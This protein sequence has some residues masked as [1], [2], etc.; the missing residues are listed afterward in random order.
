MR[1]IIRSL[2]IINFCIYNSHSIIITY[3][4]VLISAYRSLFQ[5]NAI[6]SLSLAICSTVSYAAFVLKL[7]CRGLM[8][9]CVIR[10]HLFM[11]KKY[12]FTAVEN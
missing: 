2:R 6:I 10:R 7:N 11:K 5:N 3:N 12:I 4:V 8:E 1:R 9:S